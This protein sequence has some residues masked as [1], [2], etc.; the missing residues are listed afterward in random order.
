VDWHQLLD[1]PM[2]ELVRRGDIDGARATVQAAI[3]V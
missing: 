2:L 1:G 3:G